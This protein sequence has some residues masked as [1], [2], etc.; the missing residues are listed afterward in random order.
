[1][2]LPELKEMLAR[3]I[4]QFSALKTSAELLGDVSRVNAI[5]AEISE[6]QNTLDQLNTLP[7][8]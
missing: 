5:E 6:T 3:R 1:M 8:G 4:A 7:T 2:T